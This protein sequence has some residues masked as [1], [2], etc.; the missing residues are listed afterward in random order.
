MLC[1]MSSSETEPSA[2]NGVVSAGKM[3]DKFMI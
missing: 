2:E 3:P 1:L